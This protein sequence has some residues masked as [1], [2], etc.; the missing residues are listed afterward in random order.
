MEKKC[1]AHEKIACRYLDQ[2]KADINRRGD[3]TSEEKAVR[4]RDIIDVKAAFKNGVNGQ[5]RRNSRN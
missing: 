1:V 4:F 5:D 2:I 3:M